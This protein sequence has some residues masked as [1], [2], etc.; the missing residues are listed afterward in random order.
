MAGDHGT[1][2]DV[3]NRKNIVQSPEFQRQECSRY[4]SGFVSSH[5][6]SDLFRLTDGELFQTRLQ[7]IGFG[8]Q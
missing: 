1:A 7:S 2:E 4:K 5:E 6:A 3:W 8:T